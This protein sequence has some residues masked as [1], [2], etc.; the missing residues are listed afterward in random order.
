MVSTLRPSEQ[1]ADVASAVDS[2]ET[3]YGSPESGHSTE[4]TAAFANGSIVAGKYL[5]EATLAEGGVGTVASAMHVTLQQRVAI[6]YLKPK[7][8]AS[9]SLVERFVREARLAAQIRSEH[10]VRVHDV[11]ILQ[12]GALSMQAEANVPRDIVNV[13]EGLVI[14]ALAG[15]R[16]VASRRST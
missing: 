5:I 10:V 6:K 8:L 16:Y 9:P 11:G 13:V 2:A 7:A 3:L 14:I 12:N 4:P 1:R 15:R